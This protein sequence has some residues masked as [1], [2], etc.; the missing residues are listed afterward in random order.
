MSQSGEWVLQL[1]SGATVPVYVQGGR[2]VARSSL[3]DFM[4]LLSKR[5]ADTLMPVIS[6]EKMQNT[7]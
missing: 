3:G 2:H 1:A 6:D 7:I 5:M 4:D